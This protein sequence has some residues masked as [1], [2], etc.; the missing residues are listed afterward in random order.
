MTLRLLLV[1]MKRGPVDEVVV[2]AQGTVGAVASEAMMSVLRRW[3]T[4]SIGMRKWGRRGLAPVRPKIFGQSRLVGMRH[5][6]SSGHVASQLVSPVLR[7][8]LVTTLVVRTR[9]VAKIRQWRTLAAKVGVG[10]GEDSVSRW[11]FPKQTYGL[12]AMIY[13]VI[14]R[15]SGKSA[16]MKTMTC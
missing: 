11:G 16:S 10:E 13:G 12:V 8:R 5:G 15:V 4:R 14:P 9:V 2:A 3:K 1:M 6:M 7:N